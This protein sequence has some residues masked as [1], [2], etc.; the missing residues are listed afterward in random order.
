VLDETIELQI[1][2]VELEAGDVKVPK[3]T[4]VSLGINLLYS[5]SGRHVFSNV[6]P[7]YEKHGRNYW[8]YLTLRGMEVYEKVYD[9]AK[10]PSTGLVHCEQ[11]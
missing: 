3:P 9:T 2:A 10:D 11:P 5:G 1:K 8:N 7:I 6:D 4:A